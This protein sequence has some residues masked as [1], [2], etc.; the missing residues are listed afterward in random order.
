MKI[1]NE[2]LE[3]LMPQVS[4]PKAEPADRKDFEDMLARQLGQE[5]GVVSTPDLPL[6]GLGGIDPMLLA[7][8]IESDDDAGLLSGLA[9]QTDDLLGD[10]EQYAATLGSGENGVKSAWA[11]LAGMDARVQGLRAEMGKLGTR[12]QG[13]GAVINELEVLTATEKF[14]F[15]RGDYQ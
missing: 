13:L 8:Q 9:G 5:A 15:N 10:W 6:A 3:G 4:A 2:R 7:D 1:R 14:K 12:A 11:M